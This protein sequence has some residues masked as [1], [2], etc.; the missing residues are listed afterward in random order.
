[1]QTMK[2]GGLAVLMNCDCTSQ[3]AIKG[4]RGRYTWGINI[5]LLLSVLVCYH[6]QQPERNASQQ[7]GCQ[8]LCS[9]L[10]FLSSSMSYGM[11]L[12]YTLSAKWFI[13]SR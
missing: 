8:L 10:F 4:I 3:T 1:M 13:K 12:V 2:Q 6:G 5:C 9:Y 7:L 11:G